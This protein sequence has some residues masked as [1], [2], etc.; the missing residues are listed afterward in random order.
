[1]YHPRDGDN[2]IPGKTIGLASTRRIISASHMCLNSREKGRLEKRVQYRGEVE[3]AFGTPL[4]CVSTVGKTRVPSPDFFVLKAKHVWLGVPDSF[5]VDVCRCRRH[6]RSNRGE[7]GPYPWPWRVFAR[8]LLIGREVEI[9][10]PMNRP[11]ASPSVSTTP[12]DA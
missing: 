1:M 2:P 9:R 6:P 5:S 10:S 8:Q 12:A 4:F 7:K 3:P 11:F